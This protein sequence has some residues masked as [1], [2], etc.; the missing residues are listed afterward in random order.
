[1]PDFVVPRIVV[2]CRVNWRI[3]LRKRVHPTNA[4]IIVSVRLRMRDPW[5]HFDVTAS[6]VFV[7]GRDIVTGAGMLPIYQTQT[8]DGREWME[9]RDVIVIVE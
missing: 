7:N 5:Y 8:A 2:S 6:S 1:M 9:G 4:A 3:R